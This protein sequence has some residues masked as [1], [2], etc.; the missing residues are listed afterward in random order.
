[1][2]PGWFGKLPC[3]GDFAGRRLP[4]Q[5]IEPWDAWLADGLAAARAQLGEAWL[6]GY[7]VAPVL[8]FWLAPAALGTAQAW[9][10]LLMPS[11]DR[12]GRHYPLTLATDAEDA[13]AG[14]DACLHADAWFDRLD[15]IA[16]GMLDE[17]ATLD[18]LEAALE[19]LH[20]PW[21][22]AELTCIEPRNPSPDGA[23]LPSAARDD[24]PSA[25]S[26]AAGSPPPTDDGL[27][28]P[29]TDDLPTLPDVDAAT[30]QDAARR[31][32]ALEAAGAAG[33]GASERRRWP[34]LRV[35]GRPGSLWWLPGTAGPTVLRSYAGLPPVAAFVELLGGSR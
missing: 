6:D 10:G 4:S 18:R 30:D 29:G 14:P 8:R 1:M 19:G 22:P 28:D 17:R 21:H 7:L 33:H 15:D 24:H 25:G 26:H 13:P 5:F 34:R 35:D 9:A 20:P 12:V 2:T 3:L 32:A 27:T 11:V 31:R 16:R 23:A